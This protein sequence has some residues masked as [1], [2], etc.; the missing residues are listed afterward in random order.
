MKQHKFDSKAGPRRLASLLLAGLL[1]CASAFA[2]DL[3]SAKEDGFIGEQANGYLGLVRSD[4]PA[5]VRALV[6]DVNDKRRQRYQ[7][8]A[9]QQ[10]T[11]LSEVEKVGGLKAI[12][13]TARG[14]Y[15]KDTQGNWIRK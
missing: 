3:G 15:V 11:P 9:R 13:M 6:S 8:I 10:G 4:A 2:A 12:E 7:E 1:A 5:D 14:H